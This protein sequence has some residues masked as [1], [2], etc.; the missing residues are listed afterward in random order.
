MGPLHTCLFTLLFLFV[1][2]CAPRTVDKEYEDAFVPRAHYTKYKELVTLFNQLQRSYPDLAKVYS[3]GKSVEGRDLL[4]LQITKDVDGT[5]ETRP[6]FK[7]VAN[8][9]GDESVGRELVVYLAQYLLMSYGKDERVTALLNNTDIH[10][11]PSLNPDGYEMS[12]V[13]NLFSI[14]KIRNILF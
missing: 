2:E 5:H 3:V 4:V 12:N 14:F 1:N 7:Y 6:R 8:M 10:L 9:H 11:M 13:S